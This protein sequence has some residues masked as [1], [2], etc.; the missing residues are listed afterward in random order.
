[1][2]LKHGR[3]RAHHCG[4]HKADPFVVV[5]EARAQAERTDDRERERGALPRELRPL[6]RQAGVARHSAWTIAN[7]I[8]PIERTAKLT[9]TSAGMRDGGR[10]C[11]RAIA[12]SL[13]RPRE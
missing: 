7:T 11:S 12:S 13:A 1:G 5:G 4:E 6:G 9:A 2:E 8:A 10:S 3:D